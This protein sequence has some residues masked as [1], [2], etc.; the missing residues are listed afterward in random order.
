MQMQDGT[1][2]RKDGLLV[3]YELLVGRV[4]F[5]LHTGP[6]VFH[7]ARTSDAFCQHYGLYCRFGYHLLLGSTLKAHHHLADVFDVRAGR[8]DGDCKNSPLSG[9]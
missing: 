2:R 8:M 1:S 7:P 5:G 4:R 3:G 6:H 9:K